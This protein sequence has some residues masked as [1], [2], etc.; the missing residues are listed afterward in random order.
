[1]NEQDVHILNEIFKRR[2]SPRSFDDKLVDEP[3]LMSIFEAAKWAASS[4]NEQPWRFIYATKDNK[5]D[6]NRLLSCLSDWNQVWVKTAPVIIM[7]VAKTQFS[8]NNKENRHAWHDIGLA[9]GNMSLQ[10]T[11]LG[12]FLHQMAGFSKT[13]AIETL[14][15]PEGY[16]P[17]TMIALGYEGNPEK[18]PV[19]YD[20]L[21]GNDRKRKDLKDIVF[22]GTFKY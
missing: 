18:L 2:Y 15:I 20:V 7:T 3:E 5:K 8:H 12:L 17:V 9:V 6:Y 1:M 4:R 19:E 13:K 22:K 14:N 10:A 16:E 11:E 21:T